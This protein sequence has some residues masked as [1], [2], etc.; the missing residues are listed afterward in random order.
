MSNNTSATVRGALYTFGGQWGKFFIQLCALVVLSRML[1]TADFGVFAMVNAISTGA[2]LL[3]DFGLSAATIS[4]KSVT[5]GEQTNVFWL[6]VGIGS[7]LCIAVSAFSGLVASFYNVAAVQATLISVSFVFVTQS[8]SSQFIAH[9]TRSLRFKAL[10]F[11]DVGAQ[12]V[13]LVLAVVVAAVGGGYWALVA[14]QIGISA[15]ALITYITLS[16]WRPGLPRRSTSIRRF[17]AFGVNTTAVQGL[18]YVSQNVDTVMLGRVASAATV[19]LYD[20]AY[21][22]LKIPLQQIAG[23]LTRVALPTLSQLPAERFSAA[24]LKA[25]KILVY[26]LG[27]VFALLVACAS[28]VMVIVLGAQWNGSA[29]LFTVLCL[30]GIFQALGYVYYWV[31]LS[32]NLTGMQLRF[33]LVTRTFMVACV[34]TGSFFGAFGVATAVSVGLFTNWLVLTLF[35]V[36]RAGISSR[37][38]VRVS[39]LPFAV[40]VTS[41]AITRMVF[42]FALTIDHVWLEL[43]ARGGSLLLLLAIFSLVIPQFRRDCI[44]ILTLVKSS[45]RGKD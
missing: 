7:L 14:Q 38:I 13:G 45:V 21:Q 22:L 23:P 16:D 39:A 2:L 20:R 18:N 3:S 26:V 5:P 19:G 8:A 40:F 35:A 1:T 32:Q 29:E 4:A 12:F 6:N 17:V 43:V 42:D 41:T 30:G 11:V 37:A 36:P 33:S 15:I 28:P 10:G 24:V 9:L 25:Q 34:I 44:E 27:L 31:F